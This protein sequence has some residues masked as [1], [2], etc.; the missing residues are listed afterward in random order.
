MSRLSVESW[1]HAVALLE[2]ELATGLDAWRDA[3]DWR[4]TSPDLN[5]PDACRCGIC[6]VCDDSDPGGP[7]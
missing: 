7:R 2:Y 6:H 1:A 5:D 4:E 3:E